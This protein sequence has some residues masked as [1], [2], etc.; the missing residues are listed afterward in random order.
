LPPVRKLTATLLAASCLVGFAC[1]DDDDEPD[2]AAEAPASQPAEDPAAGG[3]NASGAD[4][5]DSAVDRD[6]LEA[7]APEMVAELVLTTT[8]PEDG[9]APP[10]VT[11][12]Y[13]K[14]AYG[15]ASGCADALREGGPIAQRVIVEPVDDSAEAAKTVAVAKGGVYDGEEIQVSLVRDVE[16]WSVDAIKVDVPAGP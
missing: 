14:A 6:E 9:C 13:V 11:E 1:G 12:A 15:S 7:P 4:S 16:V 10:H 3:G 8:N 2:T 5:D